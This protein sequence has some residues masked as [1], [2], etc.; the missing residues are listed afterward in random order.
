[1][2][3]D[4]HDVEKIA[5]ALEDARRS[6]HLFLGPDINASGAF[7]DLEHHDSGLAIRHGLGALRGVGTGMARDVV[8]ERTRNGPFT[9][10]ADFVAR[11]KTSINRKMAD[12]LIQA[13]AL[14]CLHSNRA[15]MMAALPDL[16]TDAGQRA[17]EKDRGQ[18]T[19]FD[20]MPAAAPVGLPDIADWSPAERQHRQ[21]KVVGFYLDGHPISSVRPVLDRFDNSR[22]IADVLATPVDRLPREIVMGGMILD[23]TFKRTSRKD[24][25]LILKISDETGIHEV[26]AFKETAD[27]IRTRLKKAASPAVRLTLSAS[28]RDGDLSLFVRD[29]EALHL[30]HFH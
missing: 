23:T 22:T 15:A 30:E 4:I 7:F 17:A 2:N 8:E 13:G 14:D 11:T 20:M 1:M 24:P 29:L 18:M 21:F 27:D 25:M 12:S 16:L 26:I 3:Y 9:D 6:G 5:E 19:M 10:L 28:A